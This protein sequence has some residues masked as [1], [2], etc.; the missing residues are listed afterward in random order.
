MHGA[1]NDYIYV[2][3]SK[4]NLPVPDKMAVKLCRRHFS[5][6]GDGLVLIMPSL[7]ADGKMKM[8]NADGSEG[9][10]CGNAIRCV[11][12]FLYEH[13]KIKKK[14]LTVE[15]NAGIKKLRLKVVGRK[16]MSVSVDMGKADFTPENVPVLSDGE[17]IEKEFTCCGETVKGTAV[18]MGNPHNV[19]FVDSVSDLDLEKIGPYYENNP[20]FPNRVNTEFIRVISGTELEMR[21]WERGSGETLACGTGACASVAAAVKTGRCKANVPVD[22]KLPGGTLTVTVAKDYS[23][24][25]EGPCEF[26]Y[27]GTIRL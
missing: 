2:D 4:Q 11:G 5:I 8:Y 26:V 3:C 15:T 23:V 1:G 24:T 18:S 6:G 14:T 19:I 9:D 7:V 16:V 27:R 17:M 13:R 22:V 25:L 20:I 12:A 21:V 10:M